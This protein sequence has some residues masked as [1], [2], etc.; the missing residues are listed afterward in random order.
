MPPLAALLAG[1]SA[2]SRRFLRG[3]VLGAIVGAILA[4]SGLFRRRASGAS[5]RR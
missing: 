3:I 2:E 4:G 1:D 5:E